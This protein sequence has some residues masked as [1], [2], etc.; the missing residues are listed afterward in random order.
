MSTKSLELAEHFLADT[1]ASPAECEELAKEI[2]VLC[3]EFCAAIESDDTGDV[4]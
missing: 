1:K 2:Q 3:E 4:A